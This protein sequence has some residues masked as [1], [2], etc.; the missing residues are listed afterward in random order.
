VHLR[1]G[2]RLGP[3]RATQPLVVATVRDLQ[4]LTHAT[5]L[6]RG[7]LRVEPGVLHG[8]GGAKDAAAC[9]RRSRASVQR[10]LSLRRRCSSSYRGS[11]WPCGSGR[12]AR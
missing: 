3:R 4:E 2:S 11:S 10:A 7:V 5:H 6:A 9:F 1:I 12:S 8:S